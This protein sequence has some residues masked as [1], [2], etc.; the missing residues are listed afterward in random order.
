[1]TDKICTVV[2]VDCSTAVDTTVYSMALWR[3]KFELASNFLLNLH[4]TA[5]NTSY[6]ANF[7]GIVF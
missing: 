1:M 7:G 6:S 3:P 5:R 4:V 2:T